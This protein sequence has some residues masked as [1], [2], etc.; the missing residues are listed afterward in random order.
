LTVESGRRA[1]FPEVFHWITT[2]AYMQSSRIRRFVG[3]T[4]AL[5]L[6]ICFQGRA[7]AVNFVRGDANGVGGVDM[8]DAM[9]IL[10][11]KF[12][13]GDAPLCA[14]TADANDDGTTDMSDA[15][16]LLNFLFLGQTSIPAPYPECGIDPTPDDLSCTPGVQLGACENRL[17]TTQF[18]FPEDNSDPDG[19]I[20]GRIR[21]ESGNPLPFFRVSH[22]EFL[23]PTTNYMTDEDG[24]VTIES[25]G[26]S[27]DGS[28]TVAIYAQNPV[29]RMLDGGFPFTP[30]VK[31]DVTFT[32]GD[33]V[34]IAAQ[35]E[36]FTIADG[37]RQSYDNGLREFGPWNNSQFANSSDWESDQFIHVTIPDLFPTLLTF[38]EPAALGSGMP[39][40]HLKNTSPGTMRH[41]LGHALHFGKVSLDTRLRGEIEYVAWL[42]SNIDS[43]FHNLSIETNP[44]VA[45]IEA[46]GFFADIYS[47]LA[48]T[49][50][51]HE[52][53]YAAASNGLEGA[54]VEGAV[55]STIFVDFAQDPNV[56]L[57]YAV[58]RFVDCESLTIFEY[59][60][61]VRDREGENSEIYE[62][63][64]VA[65]LAHDIEL[66]GANAFT[67]SEPGFDPE[68][69]AD[70]INDQL[71]NPVAEEDNTGRNTG[72]PIQIPIDIGEIFLLGPRIT[73][74]TIPAS[75]TT[76]AT[77]DFSV[78]YTTASRSPVTVT[79]NFGDGQIATGD[80]VSHSYFLTGTYNVTVTVQQGRRQLAVQTGQIVVTLPRLLEIPQR[81]LQLPP[82]L[83][84]SPR[85]R[86]KLPPGGLKLSGQLPMPKR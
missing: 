7:Q 60:D 55:L 23:G 36:W 69:I 80:S 54:S 52:Q 24:F 82:D 32:D 75:G 30:P 65:G 13:D 66:P 20:T 72:S 14:D 62:A 51:K 74:T 83:L 34:N 44:I 81:E 10:N 70:Q 59:A 3:I 53:F 16:S 45:Y 85:P 15:V 4:A 33:T 49:E 46:F 9:F 63:L 58:S 2:E 42:A 61:C 31:Q 47:N 84:E 78:S 17:I 25:S 35:S 1:L 11:W 57:D 28:V 50:D 22:S 67:G 76:Q 37:F 64:L 71:E 77:I 18:F 40:I 68:D 79:W 8:T 86:P 12:L 48:D 27:F 29:V 38:V 21:D 19:L 39:L 41:E 6:V 43:P 56:G 26:S 5:L 73:A